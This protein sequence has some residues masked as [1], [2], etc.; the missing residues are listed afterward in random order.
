[1]CD[2]SRECRAAA[3]RGFGSTV[4]KRPLEDAPDATPVGEAPVSVRPGYAQST[5]PGGADGPRDGGAP[6][7]ASASPASEAE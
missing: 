2:N 3:A 6:V 7:G 4:G 1:M 5:P